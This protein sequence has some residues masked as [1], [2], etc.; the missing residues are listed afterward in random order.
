M[1]VRKAY[2]CRHPDLWYFD[3]LPPTANAAFNWSAGAI[4]NGWKRGEAGYRTGKQIAERVAKADARQINQ[5][6]KRVWSVS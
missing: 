6:Q 3:Q 2:R 5:D 1:I 4:L